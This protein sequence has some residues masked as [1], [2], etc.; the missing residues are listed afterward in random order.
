M[1]HRTNNKED[2]LL[3]DAALKT[4]AIRRLSFVHRHL[5]ASSRNSLLTSVVKIFTT[6]VGP[7]YQSPWQRQ[8]E[9]QSTGTGFAVNLS[10]IT[11]T[12]LPSGIPNIVLLTNNHVIRNAT[13]VRILRHGQPGK[14]IGKILCSSP[15]CDLAI[16]SVEDTDFWHSIRPLPFAFDLHSAENGAILPKLGEN[17]TAIG[18]PMGGENISVTRGVV[19]RID[20]LDYTSL[21][22]SGKLLVVQIDA[23]INPGN[24]GGPVTNASQKCVGVAFAGATRG[25]SIGYIIPLPVVRMFILN[26]YDYLSDSKNVHSITPFPRL[27]SLGLSLQTTESPSLRK[28]YKLTGSSSSSNVDER[29]GMLVLKDPPPSSPL[30]NKVKEGDIVL[31]IAGSPVS[32]DGT[33]EVRPGSRVSLLYSVCMRRPGE[34]FPLIISRN[35]QKITININAA[36][37]PR[38]VPRMHGVDAYPSYLVI[39]GLVF[40]PLTLPW[41]R[42]GAGGNMGQ[43]AVAALLMHAE[44]QL[45]KEGQQVIVLSNVLSHDVNFG[46]ERFSGE[47]LKSLNGTD[48]FNLKHLAEVIEESGKIDAFSYESQLYSFEFESS[49]KILLNREESVQAE[50]EILSRHSIPK[51]LML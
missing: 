2:V 34:I 20:L 27:S 41:M 12:P 3:T 23:A 33:V 35:G 30:T 44:K 22:P 18:Y 42:K 15:E 38:L 9:Q 8:R 16:V 26:S 10:D 49:R 39:G 14:Y 31:S 36:P 50:K 28:H 5:T 46:Y 51:A 45:E 4:N 48:I 47:I 21:N 7:N 6:S 1:S 37:V 25:N 32:E 24:S 11:T 29:L 17:C 13:T 40:V 19:S 43:S